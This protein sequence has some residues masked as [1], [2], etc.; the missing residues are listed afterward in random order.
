MTSLQKNLYALLFVFDLARS[1]LRPDATSVILLPKELLLHL[2]FRD[3]ET[4]D[5][6][7]ESLQKQ[8]LE[9]Y[10]FR[11]RSG[12]LVEFPGESLLRY[13]QRYPR[14]DDSAELWGCERVSIFVSGYALS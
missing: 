14:I 3:G 5:I 2:G 12:P 13:V 11:V 6:S 1:P 9:I 4:I 8:F 10:V 7:T